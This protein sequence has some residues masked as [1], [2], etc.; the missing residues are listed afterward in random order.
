MFIALFA[1]ACTPGSE[2]DVSQDGPSHSTT[3]AGTDTAGLT[4]TLS[5]TLAPETDSPTEAA[6]AATT[7]RQEVHLI[8]YAI[9]MPQTLPSGPIAF[10]IEN[11][12][13]EQHAFEIEG[14]GI[15]QKSEVL[16]RGDSTTLEV[17]LP[18]GTYTVYCPVANHAEK[19]MRTS[20][21]VK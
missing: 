13:T 16:Q 2:G 18:P 12:G 19:G 20:V 8:E 5:P 7:P 4:S 11:G 14:N 17:T 1:L 9:H 10:N 3:I 6:S 15:E 21:T